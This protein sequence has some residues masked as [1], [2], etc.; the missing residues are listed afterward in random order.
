MTRDDAFTDAIRTEPELQ[1]AGDALADL[2][3]PA[4]VSPALK[5]SVLAAIAETP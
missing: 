2:P 5:N 3:S 1:A 4:P